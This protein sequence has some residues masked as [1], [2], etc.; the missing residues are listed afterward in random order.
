MNGKSATV[1]N[2]KEFESCMKNHDKAMKIDPTREYTNSF[3]FTD[4]INFNEFIK[5][6]ASYLN[7]QELYVN[8]S[9]RI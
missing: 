8:F 4:I 7:L 2:K 6:Y 5:L 3:R 9:L 1:F